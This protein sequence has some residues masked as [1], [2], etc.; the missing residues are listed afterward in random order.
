MS[1]FTQVLL[2]SLSIFYSASGSAQIGVKAGKLA[3][4]P[5]SPN[6]VSTYGDD[7]SPIPLKNSVPNTWRAIKDSLNQFSNTEIKSETFNYLH[8]VFTSSFF[9]FKDDVEFY[10]DKANGQFHFRSASRTG[11]SDL[12]ANKKRMQKFMDHLK[13]GTKNKK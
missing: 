1:R 6:C 2:L 4:C 13:S 7:F 11:Y 10:F 9:K 8:V 5:S 12:G 3:P